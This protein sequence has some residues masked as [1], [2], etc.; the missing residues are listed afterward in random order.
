[1]I[2]HIARYADTIRD[3]DALEA[4]GNIYAVAE[5]IVFLDDYIREIDANSVLNT[6][7]VGCLRALA[8][9]RFLNLDCALH[10]A[11]G[12]VKRCQ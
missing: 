9:N 4:Y 5:N 8:H 12:A 3:G 11:D 10:G 1:M 6:A 7:V 2:V